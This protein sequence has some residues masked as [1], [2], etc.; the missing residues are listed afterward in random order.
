[1]TNN[2]NRIMLFSSFGRSYWI[3]RTVRKKVLYLGQAEINLIFVWPCII[4]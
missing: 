3:F 2:L 4:N 1:M